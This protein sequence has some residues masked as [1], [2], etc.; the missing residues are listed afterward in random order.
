MGDTMK[1][2][3]SLLASGALAQKSCPNNACSGMGFNEAFKACRD[4]FPDFISEPNYGTSD[5]Q[6][7]PAFSPNFE[8]EPMNNWADNFHRFA[9]NLLNEPSNTN[10]EIAEVLVGYMTNGWPFD[11][12]VIVVA[13]DNGTGCSGYNG[14]PS[15]NQHGDTCFDSWYSGCREPRTNGSASKNCRN[16]IAVSDNAI[17]KGRH[18]IAM[19]VQFNK[20]IDHMRYVDSKHVMW[21]ASHAEGCDTIIDSNTGAPYC[22]KCDQSNAECAKNTVKAKYGVSS[23]TLDLNND[24]HRQ[25]SAKL[26]WQH[27]R[28]ALDKEYNSI[29]D[30]Q[31]ADWDVLIT[32]CND[33]PDSL[34]GGDGHTWE[35]IAWQKVNIDN[36]Y[37]ADFKQFEIGH[38][39]GWYTNNA[40]AQCVTLFVTPFSH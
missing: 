34:P 24:V 5:E 23:S 22:S 21:W 39:D 3:S 27:Y 30:N 29:N 10:A 1:V 36:H 32:F 33:D 12:W 17:Y 38:Q 11:G 35:D 7:N 19:A 28:Q 15:D 26:I 31:C 8:I 25:M 9:I 14:M 37:N 13:M 4:Y 20:A 40:N 6:P 18:R 16:E 2:F